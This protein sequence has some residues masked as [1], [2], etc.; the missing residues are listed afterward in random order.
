MTIVQRRVYS[1]TSRFVYGNFCLI[2]RPFDEK[3]LRDLP[4]F[5]ARPLLNL[6]LNPTRTALYTCEQIFHLENRTTVAQINSLKRGKRKESR[7][8]YVVMVARSSQ[9]ILFAWC[10]FI[11]RKRK[12]TPL[13]LIF[14]KNSMV[15]N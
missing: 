14:K 12:L 6:A 4:D 9:R 8:N 2:E 11:L 13:D 3:G 1:P 5:F 7:N 15:S 10:S